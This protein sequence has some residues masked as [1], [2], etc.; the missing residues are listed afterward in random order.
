MTSWGPNSGHQSLGVALPA[1]PSHQPLPLGFSKFIVTLH[2]VESYTD[3]QLLFGKLAELGAIQQLG[4]MP[5]K[6]S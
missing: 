6:K 2:K 5:N 4:D 1:D 3:H